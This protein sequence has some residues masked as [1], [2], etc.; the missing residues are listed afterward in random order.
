MPQVKSKNKLKKELGLFSVYAIAT[1][2]TLSAGFFLLP[3]IAASQAGPAMVLA[4]LLAAVPLIPAMFSIVE[5]S[6]AMP[7]AGGVYY[8]LDRS[9]GPLFGTIGG[10]GTWLAMIL[11]VSFALVGMGYYIALFVPDIGDGQVRIIAIVLALAIGALNLFGSKKSGGLQNFLV[12]FFISLLLIFIGSGLPEMEPMHFENFFGAGF[13]AI[14][15]TAGLVYISYVG[16][17]KVAALSEEVKNPERNLPLGIFLSLVT[18]LLVYGLGTAVMVGLLPM[19]L[20]SKTMTPVADSAERLWGQPGRYLLSFAAILAFTSVA[21]AGTMSA[22]RYPMALSRDK[23]LPQIFSRL[24][25][26]VPVVSILLT[27]GSIV[28]ILLFL[29]P[30]RIAKLASA[31]QLLMFA[32]ICFAVIVMRESGLDS[33]DPGYRSPFYPWMQLIGIF[34]PL[35]FIVEMGWLPTLFSIG[36]IIVGTIWYRN[37]ARLKVQRSGAIFHIFARLGRLSQQGLDYELR[38]IMKEKGLRQKDPFDQIIAGS[39]VV[40]LEDRTTFEDAVEIVSHWF[41]ER[42]GHFPTEIGEQFLEGTRVGATPVARG[43][44]LPHFRTEGIDHAFLAIVRAPRG[45]KIEVP[46]PLHPGTQDSQL[47]QAVFFLVSPEENPALHLRLLAQIAGLVEQDGFAELW[48]RT[49]NEQEIKELLL[50]DENCM[51]LVLLGHGP[52]AQLIGRSLSQIS[53]P[54]GS[55][56]ALL[57]RNEEMMVPRSNTLL[58]ENDRMTIIGEPEAIHQLR[59]DYAVELPKTSAD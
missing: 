39:Y 57:R 20:L 46:H 44:A 10:M 3:G 27:V 13:D 58:L 54:E 59:R 14:I 24:R 28:L 19:E 34:A 16:V 50:R 26:G 12:F 51:S 40:T 41:A 48:Q 32:L 22:S 35:W 29:D 5:L 6:T 43:V 38:E 37:Y 55:L 53:L 21:N 4:Y 11:K 56:I 31:F 9:L 18:A 47:V 25:D 36:L 30:L 33:Y 2:T 15:S 45:L 7:R 42:L 49:S 1:G 23:M 52:T 17:T 8:F